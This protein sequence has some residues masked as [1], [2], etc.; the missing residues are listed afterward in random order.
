MNE[1]LASSLRLLLVTDDALLNGADPVGTCLAAIAGGVT[2]IQ[3]RLKHAGDQDYLDLA[4]QLRRAITVP[5]FINDRLDIALA[6]GAD[7]VHLGSDDLPPGAAR[8]I[9]P[10]GFVIG[11][12]VGSDGEVERGEPADYWGIGPLRVTT[13]KADAGDALGWDGARAL[14]ERAGSRP[15]VLIGG[16]QPGDM[17]AARS[18][19]FAGVAVV[20]GILG[21]DDVV[22]AA[23]RYAD[24]STVDS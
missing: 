1:N 4:R 18:A 3:L 15:C 2:A 22:A 19:G 13:T 21:A 17:A 12:S 5:L 24:G 8:R 20:S 7:G 11:A 16:V 14:R 23:R 6:A 9:A 10:A